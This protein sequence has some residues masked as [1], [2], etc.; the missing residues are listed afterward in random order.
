ML[1]RIAKHLKSCWTGGSTLIQKPWGS[2]LVWKA[3]SSVSGKI[4]S[5]RESERTS[6]KYNTLKDECLFVL[7]GLIEVM[8]GNEQTIQD[9]VQNP[10][11]HAVLNP[12]ESLSVQSGCPYRITAI[13][14]SQVIEISEAR[15]NSRTVRI[16]D[17]YGR[18]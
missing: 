9:P 12:G 10:Y 17:D 2:E 4:L 16:E 3:Q 18:K 11:Q 15:F 7:D 5:I 8:Y 1:M 13:E 6:L 14:D